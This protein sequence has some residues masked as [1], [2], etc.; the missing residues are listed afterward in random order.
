MTKRRDR[1]G[2]YVKLCRGAIGS[3]QECPSPARYYIDGWGYWGLQGTSG[4]PAYCLKDA[5]RVLRRLQREP[6]NTYK[7][8][9]AQN[10]H[11]V[12]A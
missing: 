5:R 6:R 8:R 2:R 9:D 11:A 1:N 12:V 4:A 7:I 3:D 10:D